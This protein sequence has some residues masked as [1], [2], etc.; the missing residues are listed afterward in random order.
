M[1]VI[2]KKKPSVNQELKLAEKALQA[3]DVV[4]RQ[5]FTAYDPVL[6]RLKRNRVDIFNLAFFDIYKESEYFGECLFDPCIHLL[7]GLHCMQICF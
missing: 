2:S 3:L 5:E 4:R 1:E 7:L 6:R